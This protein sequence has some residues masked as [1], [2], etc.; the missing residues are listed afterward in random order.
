MRRS[1]CRK[2]VHRVDDRGGRGGGERPRH[3]DCEQ[4][5][6]AARDH[7]SARARAAM[8]SDVA[9]V[10]AGI[11]TANTLSPICRVPL[12]LAA[13][14]GPPFSA[15]LSPGALAFSSVGPKGWRS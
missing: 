10:E 4:E 3:D 8:V 15:W 1:R 6:G 11:S 7:R 5:R 14:L 2:T 9:H 12:A 13:A